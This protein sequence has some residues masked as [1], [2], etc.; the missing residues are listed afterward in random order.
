MS[1]KSFKDFKNKS[2]RKTAMVPLN[3]EYSLPLK[4]LSVLEQVESIDLGVKP[5]T[6]LRKMTK[7]EKG[8]YLKDNP[9]VNEALIAQY[10]VAYIDETDKEYLDKLKEHNNIKTLLNYVKYIDLKFKIDKTELWKDLGLKNDKDYI[11]LVNLMFKEW[12]LGEDVLKKMA[13]SINALQGDP[14]FVKLS[15]LENL[16]KD[17]SMFDLVEI[18]NKEAEKANGAE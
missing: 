10:R 9:N 13:V 5:P 8:E 7:E 15:K 1:I 12:E 18:I 2:F 14:L 3:E 11:G 16:Y 17:K 6:K 4:S